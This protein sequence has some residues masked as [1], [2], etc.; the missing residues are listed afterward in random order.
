MLKKNSNKSLN[1]QSRSSKTH[2]EMLRFGSSIGFGEA[3]CHGDVGT[4]LWRPWGVPGDPCWIRNGG[5]QG[6]MNMESWVVEDDMLSIFWMDHLM[7]IIIT[8]RY[9]SSEMMMMMMM[10]MNICIIIIIIL[11]M[12]MKKCMLIDLLWS[13]DMPWLFGHTGVLSLIALSWSGIN[14]FT[15][16]GGQ[17]QHFARFE[18]WSLKMWRSKKIWTNFLSIKPW[19]TWVS[20]SNLPEGIMLNKGLFQFANWWVFHIL[21][22]SHLNRHS[23]TVSPPRDSG[24][25]CKAMD[26]VDFL[27]PSS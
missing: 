3:P 16:Y 23:I 26:L 1:H 13:F 2:F 10:M 15:S 20:I 17:V 22:T 27:P 19:N 7:M 24:E 14:S 11:M 4:C 5:G 8:V 6:W 18:I 9:H 21:P 12:M 25:K